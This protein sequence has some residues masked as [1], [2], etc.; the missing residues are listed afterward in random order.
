[1]VN[2]VFW[3]N[4][5]FYA[6]GLFCGCTFN[7][8]AK[9]GFKRR[10]IVLGSWVCCVSGLGLAFC[11]FCGLFRVSVFWVVWE[12]CISMIGIGAS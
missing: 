9:T 11:G 4:N 6:I 12:L 10:F 3:H 1:M 5:P 8:Y 2:V 7:F